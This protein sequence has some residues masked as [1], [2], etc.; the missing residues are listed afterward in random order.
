MEMMKINT[1]S[2]EKKQLNIVLKLTLNLI[3]E[4]PRNSPFESI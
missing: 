2:L 4:C 1:E 3:E